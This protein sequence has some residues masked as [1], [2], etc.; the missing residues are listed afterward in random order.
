MAAEGVFYDPRAR[1]T[2]YVMPDDISSDRDVAIT[3]DVWGPDGL[4]DR[5]RGTIR[6][7]PSGPPEIGRRP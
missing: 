2:Q 1:T 4:A 7:V 6:V 3:L 5:R